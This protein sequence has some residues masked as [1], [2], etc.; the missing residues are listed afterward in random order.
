VSLALVIQHAKGLRH[1]ALCSLPGYTIFLHV[2][3]YKRQGF[4]KK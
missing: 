1:I 3:L 2:I 4:K